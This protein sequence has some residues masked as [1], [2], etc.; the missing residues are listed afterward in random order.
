MQLLILP[1]QRV[2]L[3]ESAKNMLK[4]LSIKCEDATICGPF[5]TTHHYKTVQIFNTQDL[6]KPIL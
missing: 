1:S 2:L 5:L 4:L 6:S 3:Y